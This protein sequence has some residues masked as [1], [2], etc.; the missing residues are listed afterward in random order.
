MNITMACSNPIRPDQNK[1]L[2]VP[3]LG[4]SE[5]GVAD[6]KDGSEVDNGDGKKEDRADVE[7]EARRPKPATRPY[8]PTKE[9]IREHEVTHLPYRPWCQH[10]VFCKGRSSPQPASDGREKLGIT[11]RL[12]YCFMAD[13]EEEGLT[14]V[15]ILWDDNRECLWAL[16]VDKKGAMDWVAR[17]V[18][19]KLDNV[20]YRGEQL[21]LK[22]EQEPAIT[23]LKMAIAATRVGVTIP[24]ESPVWE[25]H[26][27]GAAERAIKSWQG[28]MRTMKSHFEENIG[29]KLPVRH[30][31]TGWLVLWGSVVLLKF[32]V[33]YCG[34]TAYD[35]ITGH[36]VKHAGSDVR[37][38]VE[39]QA[40]AGRG[41]EEEDEDGVGLGHRNLCW[42]GP[43]NI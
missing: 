37:R 29:A 42:S 20:G 22:S 9:E 10:C 15:L 2:M 11:I 3:V 36:R 41:H 1:W 40:Q 30:P 19:E 16:P 5:G 14:G 18:V 31:L 4:S 17:W 33:R 12:D 28:Q 24:I 6:G 25:S 23:A 26:C 34:R 32:V 39:L 13:E 8:T 7:D 38:H 21:T 35:N 27:N 43:S